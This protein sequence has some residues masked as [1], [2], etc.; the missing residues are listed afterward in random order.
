[1]YVLPVPFHEWAALM[2]VLKCLLQVGTSSSTG[3]KLIIDGTA[4]G[5][6]VLRSAASNQAVLCKMDIVVEV[7]GRIIHVAHD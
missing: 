7:G 1:M 6:E 2:S 4:C 5:P 3:A